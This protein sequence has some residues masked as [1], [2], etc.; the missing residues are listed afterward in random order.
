MSEETDEITIKQYYKKYGSVTALSDFSFQT[1]D[2]RFV[3]VVGPS[4]CGKTTL[5]RIIAGLT[6]PTSGS[7]T[8]DGKEITQLPCAKRNVAMVF[9]TMR[10]HLIRLFSKISLFR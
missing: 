7:I 2:K 6:K 5:L 10:F 4:G 8:V 3:A 1:E 9:K